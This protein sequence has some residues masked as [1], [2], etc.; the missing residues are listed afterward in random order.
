[1]QTPYQLG[2][3]SPDTLTAPRF[4]GPVGINAS[5]AQAALHVNGHVLLGG[6]SSALSGN[7][8]HQTTWRYLDDGTAWILAPNPG[9]GAAL[10][11][12]TAISGSPTA[13]IAWREA[14][15]I[16]ASDGRLHVTS[17]LSVA[18][19]IGLG[20][21]S[22]DAISVV[23]R[24]TSSLQWQ[25]DGTQ[26][27][28]GLGVNRPRDLNLSRNANVGAWIKSNGLELLSGNP[29]V[30][31]GGVLFVQAAVSGG[32][33]LE[34]YGPANGNTA[35]LDADTLLLRNAAG[36][37]EWL[38]INASGAISHRG[39]ATVIIDANSHIGLRSYTVATLPSA[40]TPARMVHV[41]NGNASRMLAVADGSVW[42]WPDGSVVS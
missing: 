14:F 15:H 13:P 26:D 22:T 41:S 24:F 34:L 42:R 35:A 3:L 21:Q 32:A 30:C 10:A 40:A 5:T 31:G 9:T 36:S 17:G 27:I 39:N 38:R 6:G 7:A 16:Q 12:N 1:M 25:T 8:Y 18:G 29:M 2:P 37:S 4:T 33:N 19:T 20:S 11:L 28:G 23:G